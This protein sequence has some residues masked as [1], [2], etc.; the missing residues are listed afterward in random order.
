MSSLEL[1][2]QGFLRTSERGAPLAPTSLEIKEKVRR[3]HSRLGVLGE[4]NINDILTANQEINRAFDS[5]AR[6][7]IDMIS[8]LQ[9]LEPKVAPVAVDEDPFF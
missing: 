2:A 6:Q 4:Y 9:R 8:Q 5:N 3:N 1:I 7:N